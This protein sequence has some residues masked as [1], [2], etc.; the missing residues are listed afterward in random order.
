MET[1]PFN[2]NRRIN[3]RLT[4]AEHRRLTEAWQKS[5]D[6]KL[7]DYGRKLL[8]GKPVTVF[9]RDR[10]L[11]LFIAEM[12]RLRK[13]LLALGNNFNQVVRRINGLRE[14]PRF[15]VWLR[16]SRQQ[17]ALILQLTRDIQ[18]HIIQNTSLWSRE[19]SREK[20]SKAP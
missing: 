18:Q 8:L 5:S 16:D 9:I 12:A 10:S 2:R 14:L 15:E 19:S 1:K 3:F 4:E 11:D 6:R 17:Q 13:E 7:S 20:A